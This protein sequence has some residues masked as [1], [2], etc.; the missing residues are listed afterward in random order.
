MATPSCSLWAR[1]SKEEAELQETLKRMIDVASKS[2]S[3]GELDTKLTKLDDEM[4]ARGKV[5]RVVLTG[6][7]CGGKSTIMSDLIQMLKA[8]GYLVFTMPEIATQVRP[9]LEGP[10]LPSPPP[11]NIATQMFQWSDGKMWDDFSAQGP[12][13]DAVWASLQTTLTKVQMVIE[14]SILHMAYRSLAKRRHEPNPPNGV[15]VL[16]DRGVIDN[17]AYCTPEA[18]SMVLEELGTTTARLR[19]GRYDHIIHLVTAA[20]GAEPFYSLE[21]AGQEGEGGEVS[22]R[23]ESVEQAR[24]LDVQTL[25]AWSGAKNHWIVGNEQVEDSFEKKREKVKDILGMILG[26]ERG[27]SAL[28]QQIEC[29]YLP[30]ESIMA[31]ALADGTIRSAVSEHVTLTYLSCTARLQKTECGTGQGD[32]KGD[33][34]VGYFYQD[35]DQAG[36]VLRQYPLDWWS[37]TQK[38]RTALAI[39]SE[40]SSEAGADLR[41]VREDRVSFAFNENRVQC[42]CLHLESGEGSETERRRKLAVE[43]CSTL[44]AKQILPPWLIAEGWQ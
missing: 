3:V 34:S 16:L 35:V 20:N 37:Y 40:A 27:G 17:V 5:H 39:R 9:A 31:L 33:M 14:D 24:E 13:D 11:N 25:D 10:T 8:R 22:A 19:D 28:V 4:F 36:R 6:G 44:P 15:V 29:R 18:W 26:D 2:G 21:Q 43:V 30:P 23:T 41:E 38:R 1:P 7:P 32:R 12:E 42:H